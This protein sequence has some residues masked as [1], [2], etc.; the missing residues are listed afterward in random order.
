[1]KNKKYDIIIY[2][3]L[4]LALLIIFVSSNSYLNSSNSL[5]EEQTPV[6]EESPIIVEKEEPQNLIA[7]DKNFIIRKYLISLLDQ[8]NTNDIITYDTIRSWGKYEVGEIKYI[9]EIA[10]NYHSYSVNIKI[11]NQKAILPTIK[12]KELSTDT[13]NVITL[14]INIA[15]DLKNNNHMIKN[16]EIPRQ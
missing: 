16:I 7:I 13:Y 9:R 11:S 14:N 8:I 1:M 15:F 4:I 10:E 2:S 12:N 5:I 6:I 3:C